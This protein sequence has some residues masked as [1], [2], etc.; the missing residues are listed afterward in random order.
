MRVPQDGWDASD[1]ALAQVERSIVACYSRLDS[2]QWRTTDELGLLFEA[3]IRGDR[4]C[5]KTGAGSWVSE[6][7]LE[8]FEDKFIQM[9]CVELTIF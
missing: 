7:E 3:I 6:A 8:A 4:G 9:I 1:P 5:A 2:P